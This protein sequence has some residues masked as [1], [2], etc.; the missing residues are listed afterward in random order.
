[1]RARYLAN[2]GQR[3]LL[4]EAAAGAALVLLAACGGGSGNAASPATST[5]SVASPTTGQATPP[6]QTATVEQYASIIAKQK[7]DLTKYLDELTGPDCDWTSP[8]SVQVDPQL[9]GCWTYPLTLSYAASTLSLSLT[10]AQKQGVPAYIGA[11]PPELK[12]IVADTIAAADKFTPD[13][14]NT[15]QACVK[16]A[17][18]DCATTLFDF[19]YN[20]K[21]LRDQLAAWSPY[22]V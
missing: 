19:S 8:G 13:S 17:G 10:G 11:V 1:M 20:M 16:A 3:K 15:I 14:A 5:T 2:G 22:G 18:T 6:E 7:P 9:I 21:Q 4:S 12:G